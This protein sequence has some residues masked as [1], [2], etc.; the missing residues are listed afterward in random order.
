[1]G[2]V[3]TVKASASSAHSNEAVATVDENEN[4]A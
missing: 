3:Q 2:E 1:L 4:A